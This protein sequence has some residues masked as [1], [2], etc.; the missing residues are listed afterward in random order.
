MAD[1]EVKAK[2]ALY[3]GGGTSGGVEARVAKVEAHVEHIL[4]DLSALKADMRDIRERLAK[5]ETRLYHLPTKDFIVTAA[6]VIIGLIGTI[7]TLQQQIQ[8]WIGIIPHR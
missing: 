4:A 2:E 6:I 5:I 3:G 8:G 1:E 7:I